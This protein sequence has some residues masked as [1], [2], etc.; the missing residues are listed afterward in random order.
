VILLFVFLAAIGF[1]LM[2][3]GV[4][5]NLADVRLRF[6][7][8]LFALLVVQ[9][10]IFSPLGASLPR[11]IPYFYM[12]SLLVGALVVWLNRTLPGFRQL[13]AGL[14]ANL[15]VITINGGYM[16]VSMLAR[17]VA[18]MTPFAGV[19]NNGIEMT[20]S[21]LLWFLGDLIPLPGWL[22]LSN[23]FSVGDL[24]IS[25]GIVVFVQRT[26]VSARAEPPSVPSPAQQRQSA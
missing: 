1:A 10:V 16:P 20:S 4:L 24:L 21:T 11:G 18:G 13:L 23:V 19:Y 25:L 15:L 6:L 12:A 8:V 22:P 2:R 7:H 14:I 17:T 3:G 5:A 9:V 26:L